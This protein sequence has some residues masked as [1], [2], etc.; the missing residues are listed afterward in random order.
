M[1]Y[2]GT[3]YANPTTTNAVNSNGTLVYNANSIQLVVV[4][5]P[6]TLALAGLGVGLAGFTAWKRRRRA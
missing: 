3:A 6:G 1:R 5:E 4:P 2:N